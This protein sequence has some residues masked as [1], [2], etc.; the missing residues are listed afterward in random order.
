MYIV[1]ECEF[2]TVGQPCIIMK[3]FEGSIGDKMAHLPSNCLELEDVL[4]YGSC[5][6]ELTSY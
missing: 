1:T 3:F 4:R 2:G 5:R 6:S